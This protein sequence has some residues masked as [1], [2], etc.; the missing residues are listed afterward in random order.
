MR[1]EFSSQNINRQWAKLR[2]LWL[3]PSEIKTI[4][5]SVNFTLVT[6]TKSSWTTICQS[7]TLFSIESSVSKLLR[8]SFAYQTILL[9]EFSVLETDIILLL[10]SFHS[11]QQSAQLNNVKVCRLTKVFPVS[12]ILVTLESLTLAETRGRS[13]PFTQ[14]SNSPF[15]K[16]GSGG[17]AAIAEIGSIASR[18]KKS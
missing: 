14:T 15:S 17:G 8:A 4:K 12:D 10:L 11:W 18:F 2:C 13:C 16:Q 9:L 5:F 6:C 1:L 3:S 7:P